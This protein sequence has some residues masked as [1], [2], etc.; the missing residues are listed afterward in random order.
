MLLLLYVCVHNLA[1]V[2]CHSI[3]TVLHV[4]K[5]DNETVKK[6]SDKYEQKT[7][8]RKITKYR[9]RRDRRHDCAELHF[10][11]PCAKKTIGNLNTKEMKNPT[12]ERTGTEQ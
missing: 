3:H 11:V 7:R 8:D 9:Q 5:L 6:Q 1:E 12:Q 2:F 4:R 10:S